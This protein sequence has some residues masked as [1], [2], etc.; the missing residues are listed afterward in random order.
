MTFNAIK[1]LFNTPGEAAISDLAEE[2]DV[3]LWLLVFSGE[4]VCATVLFSWLTACGVWAGD[5]PFTKPT[6]TRRKRL[7]IEVLT[8]VSMQY[9]IVCVTLNSY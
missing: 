4:N 1:L 2:L 7:L 3:C 6:A 9:I 5:S 8:Q